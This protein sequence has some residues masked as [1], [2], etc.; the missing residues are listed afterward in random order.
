MQVS[1]NQQVKDTVRGTGTCVPGPR[2]PAAGCGR[3]GLVAPGQAA[4]RRVKRERAGAARVGKRTAR[5]RGV[6]RAS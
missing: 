1:E 4:G 3:A 2:T 6:T 5:L